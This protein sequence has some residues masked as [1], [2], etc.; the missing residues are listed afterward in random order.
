MAINKRLIKSNEGGAAVAT[1]FQT[2]TYTGNGGTQILYTTSDGTAGGTNG[3]QPDL[4][5]IKNRA[6]ANPHSLQD[7]VTGDFYLRSNATDAAAATSGFNVSSFNSN[8]ITVKDDTNGAYNV[9]GSVGGLYSGD[10]EYVAWCWKAGGSAVTNTDGTITS[11]VSANTE[12]GFSIVKFTGN[13]ISGA[14]IGH[15]LG[16]TPTI[17]IA[18]SLGGGTNWCTQFPSVIGAGNSLFLNSTVAVQNHGTGQSNRWTQTLPTSS[19]FSIGGSTELNDNGVSVIAYCFAEVEG[20]SKFGSYAGNGSTSGPTITTGFEPAFVMIKRT[21][22]T[23]QWQM[24]DNKRSP[25]NPRRAFLLAN[26]TQQ[27]VSSSLAD[28][29]FNSNGFQIKTD[30]DEYNQSGN[31]YIYM[32]FANQF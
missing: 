31:N 29:D 5:W 12:A 16:D 17:I 27:E 14:T 1:S 28:V 6:A 22:S 32:A 4:V 10:A 21:S 19:V 20:F 9:N 15:G 3:F 30:W 8:G 24:L 25:S 26:A 11:Q 23:G 2:I 18:K 13:T 7:T